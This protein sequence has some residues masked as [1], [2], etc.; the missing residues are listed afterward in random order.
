MFADEY[1]IS[2]NQTAAYKKAYPNVKK[3]STAAAAASRLLKN[4]KVSNYVNERMEELKAARVADQQEIMEY[5]SSLMRGEQKEETLVG[6][7]MG[8]QDI[9]SIEVSAKD[10]IKAAELLGKRYSLWSGATEESETDPIVIVDAWGD[11]GD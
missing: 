1:I 11:D 3:D 5:L 10:R 9:K 8:E 2:L 4:V 7:G 6:L